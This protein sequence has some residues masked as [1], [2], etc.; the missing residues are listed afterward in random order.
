LINL[1]RQMKTK[2]IYHASMVIYVFP[3]PKI[4]IT[5][6]PTQGQRKKIHFVS[7]NSKKK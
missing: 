5:K 6:S 4:Y 7:P 3:N 2:E 1:Q